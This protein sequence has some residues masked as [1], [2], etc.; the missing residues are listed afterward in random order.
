MTLQFEALGS[1]GVRILGA[2]ADS[3]TGPH[4]GEFRR[5][6]RDHRLVLLQAPDLGD[7]QHVRLTRVLGEV[8][9]ASPNMKSGRPFS[10][11]SNV[12]SDGTLR[13]GELLF[14]ADLSFFPEPLKA[15]SLYAMHVPSQGGQTLFTD[16]AQAYQRLPR[17]LR[18]T[19]EGLSARHVAT[20]GVGRKD[21]RPVYDETAKNTMS[22]VHPVVWP[23]PETGQK[24]LFVSRLLTESIIGLPP[25]ESE[26]LL[27]ELFSHIED[28]AHVQAHTWSVG[29]HLVWDNRALQ[30]ARTHF[31]PAE[32]RAMRRVPIQ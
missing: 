29:D 11:I 27:Q 1:F 8:S 23:H 10:Y 6:F 12:H 20:Y 9:F 2:D 25:D 14:H 15:I 3:L 31:D 24:I 19:L 7:E 21:T 32:K 18:Q 26:D 17:S 5:A 28:P 13:D 4:A 16:A 22:A 30:H